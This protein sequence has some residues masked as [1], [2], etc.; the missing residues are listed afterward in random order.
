MT[1]CLQVSQPDLGPR[2]EHPADLRGGQDSRRALG[3]QHLHPFCAP[4]GGR[5]R[6][7]TAP[8]RCAPRRLQSQTGEVMRCVSRRLQSQTGEVMRCDSH[9]R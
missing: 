8:P 9:V 3:G 6:S 7:G 5:P 4:S 2:G 1:D